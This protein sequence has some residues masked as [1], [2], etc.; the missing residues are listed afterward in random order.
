MLCC[1]IF[2]GING[3][4]ITEPPEEFNSSGGFFF[5]AGAMGMLC[6]GL[7]SVYCFL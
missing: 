2:K 3:S 1:F 6:R 4:S 5:Q 7:G